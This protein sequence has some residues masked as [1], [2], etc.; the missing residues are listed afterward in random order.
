MAD[1]I[2]RATRLG[3]SVLRAEP[4]NAFSLAFVLIFSA[5]LFFIS[6]RGMRWDRD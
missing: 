3:K 5:A 2:I 6:A 4:L 1:V